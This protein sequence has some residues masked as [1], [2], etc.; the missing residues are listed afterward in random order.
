M[1][2]LPTNL[3][4]PTFLVEESKAREAL[5]VGRTKELKQLK[6]ALNSIAK[7]KGQVRL[8]LGNAGKGKSYLLQK[9]AEQALATKENLLV[10][11]GYCDQQSGVGDPY[12]PC[13]HM[14]LMLLGDVE[15]QWQGGLISTAHAKRLWGA[16]RET[17]PRN[18]KTRT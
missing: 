17:V 8:V 6:Q 18:S 5:F 7:N 9:F 11:S 16:M 14:L 4:P 10:L 1:P 3:T 13:R 15:S 12:L 2:K